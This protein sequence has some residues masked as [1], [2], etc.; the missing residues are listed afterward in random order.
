M[1]DRLQNSADLEEDSVH[2]VEVRPFVHGSH[3]S[4]KTWKNSIDLM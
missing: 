4:D 1:L 3:N 2:R